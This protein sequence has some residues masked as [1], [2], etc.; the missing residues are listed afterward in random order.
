MSTQADLGLLWAVVDDSKGLIR[1]LL[2]SLKR[3]TSPANKEKK[4]ALSL[5]RHRRSTVSE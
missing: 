5:D 2:A 4:G 3:P 1:V